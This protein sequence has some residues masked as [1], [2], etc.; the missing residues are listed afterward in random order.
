M[1]IGPL[2][3]NPIKLPVLGS[4]MLG[5]FAHI[6]LSSNFSFL[7]ALSNFVNPANYALVRIE[8]TRV[9]NGPQI[10]QSLKTVKFT[11]FTGRENRPNMCESFQSNVSW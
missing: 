10:C 11:T 4:P 5:L 9:R 1:K 3:V 7:A 8:L 6:K 2:R